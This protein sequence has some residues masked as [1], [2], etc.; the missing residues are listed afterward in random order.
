MILQLL[1]CL[2]FFFFFAFVFFFFFFLILV[3]SSEMDPENLL[4]RL[5]SSVCSLS[6][7]LNA[8]GSAHFR[9]E[10][11]EVITFCVMHVDRTPL[12]EK[13][14]SRESTSLCQI[15]SRRLERVVL[16]LRPPGLVQEFVNS[17]PDG[18]GQNVV[19]WM[20]GKSE[21]V[22][23]RFSNRICRPGRVICVRAGLSVFFEGLDEGR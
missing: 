14:K 12:K 17:L 22:T 21:P 20:Y 10:E 15:P 16:I 4:G 11:G 19:I 8:C 9:C 7:D 3:V 13:Q 18:W 6:N 2:V 5:V 1:V 23:G